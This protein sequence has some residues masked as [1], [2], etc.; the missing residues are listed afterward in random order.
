MEKQEFNTEGL[1]EF[2]GID[3]DTKYYVVAPTAEDI[4]GADW[5]YSKAYT[6]SLVEGIT[7]TAE[8]TDILMRRGIIGP[9]FEQRSNELAQILAENIEALENATTNEEKQELAMAVAT[10]REELFQWNQRLNAP[11]ANTCEQIADDA[12]LEFLTSCIIVDDKGDRIWNSFEEYLV[13]KEQGL[14]QKSRFEVMLY[15][16][17]LESNFLEQTPE[18]V[19]MK[20]LEQEALANIVK[21]MEDEAEETEKTATTAATK[22]TARKTTR[23]STAKK[24]TAKK[25]TRKTTE[26]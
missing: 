7:T 25:T 17:G 3:E 16:Q 20:E 1:R 21:E 22:K 11:L 5:E 24:T 2:L 10:A 13:E 19:A 18:A 15:L 14:A 6:R 12:R 4:R 26:K 9:E 8:M 23:K